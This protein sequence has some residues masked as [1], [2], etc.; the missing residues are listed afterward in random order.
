M[1][2]TA[3]ARSF[4]TITVH[5]A[6]IIDVDK[7]AVL[8]TGRI[9]GFLAK[10]IAEGGYHVET[11]NRTEMN[12][13]V[14]AAADVVIIA[15]PWMKIA[16]AVQGSVFSGKV[17]IDATNPFD[18][19]FN[20]VR[21]SAPFTS[22]L[23]ENASHCVG[24]RLVKAFNT[25]PSDQLARFAAP[26]EAFRSALPICGDDRDA[27]EIVTQIVNAVGYDAVDIGKSDDASAQEPNG[28]YYAQRYRRTELE[29][30]E[31]ARRFIVYG[32]A[33]GDGTI[34]DSLVADD[35]VVT[36]GISPLAPMV[37]KAGFFAGL[38]ALGAFS[39]VD[40]VLEEILPST[41]RVTVKYTAHG[42]HTGDQLGVPPTQKRI[43]MKEIRLMRIRDGKI[44][45]DFVADINYDWPWLVAP[46]YR[47]AWLAK[48][49]S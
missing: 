34:L 47:D 33:R 41:D 40:L 45:E 44:V 42:T 38:G 17:V 11:S 1:H 46:R 48:L 19:T 31:V 12:A 2:A 23:Q 32:L 20:I 37:G 3:R 6:N 39:N 22:A 35:V 4:K 28:V 24:G 5:P 27:K 9:G 16:D 26:A 18:A 8:G 30:A 13:K 15:V 7:I 43:E 36:S 10:A 21:P 49:S 29:N 14:V 25:L